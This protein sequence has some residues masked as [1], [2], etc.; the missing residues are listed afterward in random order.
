MVCERGVSFGYNNLVSDM[1][2]LAIM[3]DS[4]APVVSMPPT[5][6]SCPGEGHGLRGHAGGH[7]R[8]GTGGGSRGG[9][10]LFGG[11]PPGPGEG[12]FRWA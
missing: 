6:R 2:A 4:G 1:R 8:A 7:T 9:F 3:R 10:G 5:P 12:A 11:N